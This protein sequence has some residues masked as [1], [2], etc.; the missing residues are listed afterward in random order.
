MQCSGTCWL[1]CRLVHRCCRDEMTFRVRFMGG[2]RHYLS[3]L[4]NRKGRQVPRA[5]IGESFLI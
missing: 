1:L 5:D 3:L 4:I 2:E